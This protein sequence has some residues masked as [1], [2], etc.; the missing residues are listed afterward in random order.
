MASA[1]SVLRRYQVGG[2]RVA[3]LRCSALR[4]LVAACIWDLHHDTKNYG[5]V[6]ETAK[7]SNRTPYTGSS[8]SRSFN[9]AVV[10]VL[11]LELLREG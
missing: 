6:T 11:D 9:A 2:I 8:E 4:A 3:S 1:A 5:Y 10:L 7:Q